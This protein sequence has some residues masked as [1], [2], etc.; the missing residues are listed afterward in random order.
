MSPFEPELAAIAAGR[1]MLDQIKHLTKAREN[2]VIETTLSG[3]SYARHIVQWKKLGYQVSL[4]F[5]SLPSAT[6]AVKLRFWRVPHHRLILPCTNRTLR[7]AAI[8]IAILDNKQHASESA[9]A[10]R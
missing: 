6:V 7:G 8:Q 10:T 1:V 5:L 4:T 2:F 3:L 9:K